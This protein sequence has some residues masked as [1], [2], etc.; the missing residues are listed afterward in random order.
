MDALRLLNNVPISSSARGSDHL[1]VAEEDSCPAQSD[2]FHEDQSNGNPALKKSLKKLE[3]SM[4]F[5]NSPGRLSNL[6]ADSPQWEATYKE[7]LDLFKEYLQLDTSNPPGNEMKAADF[8]KKL[9][10]KEGIDCK[11]YEPAPGRGNI[12]ARI[13]GNG[14]KKPVILLNHLDVVPADE[15]KWTVPPF[16]GQEKDG[17]IYG[18]GALDM[19]SFG[20][21]EFVTMALLKRSGE[22]LD[23]DIIFVGAADEEIGDEMGLAYL[24]D[25]VPELKNAEFCINEGT[26]IAK[27]NDGHLIWPITFSEKIPS[28][29]YVIAH[30]STGHGSVPT[31]DN[32]NMKL[33]EA[34]VRLNHWKTSLE[35]IPMVR[36]DLKARAPYVEEPL[37]SI[38][39]NIDEA[40]KDPEKVKM[41]EEKYPEINALLRDTATLTVLNS[42]NSP[43]VIPQ[44]AYAIYDGRI[45]PGRSK[46]GFLKE[47]RDIVRGLPVE[48]EA[49][50]MRYPLH[51]KIP[52]STDSEYYKAI[53]AVAQELAPGSTV[54]PSIMT[55]ATNSTFF[56]KIGIPVYCFAPIITTT[57]EESHVH[58]N[59]ERV[60]VESMKFGIRAFY[61]IMEKV[62]LAQNPSR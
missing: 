7:F 14:T 30:G 39:A 6:P 25:N 23:R 24:W 52:E 28:W 50:D 5:A 18:R 2:L 46:E 1:P 38:I 9:C 57:E 19:K 49:M 60:S 29:F 13:K 55:G 26:D 51:D 20:M 17:Y 48:I 44:E 31:V 62:S 43:N 8:F 4:G 34:L 15:S 21:M 36:D 61:K 45:L 10:D 59:D 27:M 56:R 37:K 58:G 47:V 16:S 3:Q 11:L 33:T 42:G 22:T 41:L 32:C 40:I 54:T 53:Q 35:V 12:V